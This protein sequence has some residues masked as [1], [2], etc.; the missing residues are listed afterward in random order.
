MKNKLKIIVPLCMTMLL[1]ACTISI[2]TNNTSDTT[3]SESVTSETT[4]ESTSSSSSFETTSGISSEIIS[5]VDSSSK[6]SSEDSSSEAKSGPVTL[7]FYSINDLHGRV[8]ENSSE[9]A[10]GLSKLSTYL[11]QLKAQNPTGFTFVNAGDSFQDTYESGENKGNLIAE[12]LDMSG[13]EV[14]AL[15]NHEFDWGQDAL[16]K[17][18][19][20]AGNCTFLGANV[21]DTTTNEVSSLGDPYKIIERGGVKIGIIGTIGS[22]QFTSITSPLISNLDFLNTT[23]VVKQYS[24]ELRTEKGCDVILWVNHADYDDSDPTAVTSVSS[25]SGKK[26][27]DAVFNAH[28]HQ[29][30]QYEENG[31]YFLQGASHGQYLSHISL[32][33]DEGEVTSSSYSYI[34]YYSMC[35]VSE[36]SDVEALKDKYYTSEYIT[37]RD[38]VQGTI[39][40]N[41]KIS[42]YLGGAILAKAT[43]DLYPSLMTDVDIVMNN[44]CRNAGTSGS[45]TRES[46]FNMMPFTNKTYIVSNIK[47]ED[48]NNEI[49]YN[50]YYKPEENKTF[51]NDS[52][53]TVAVIDYLL[54]HMGSSRTY[55]YFPSFS[56]SNIKGVI[57]EY[58]VDILCNYL[59]Q[60]GTINTSSF[61]G[62]SHYR[63]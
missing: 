24:D 18:K 25:V 2:K 16:K 26:Y 14:M 42:K 51:D 40:G 48:I 19:E 55:N 62:T 59:Q 21:I 57:D 49:S 12:W 4:S 52:Y 36:D 31:V 32:T 35:D 61:T 37:A 63:Y 33:V 38:A 5:S 8:N 46:L 23:S 50:Y 58:S 44:G 45:Q 30:E 60:K 28:S 11:K 22:D 9:N 43:Y 34:N 39:T 20:L 47:G 10:T 13:C 15:G 54:F 27:V 6:S 3:S 7:D 1:S 41:S 53:Y 17:N 29:Y 56:E